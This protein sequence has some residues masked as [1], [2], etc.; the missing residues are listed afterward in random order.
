MD[1]D[2]FLEGWGRVQ[3]DPTGYWYFVPSDLPPSV[4][5]SWDL[6]SRLSE[7]DR[8]LAELGGLAR[9]LPNPHLLINPFLRREA[10][11]SSRIE[12]TQA[13]LSDLFFF[14][15]AETAQVSAPDVREVL[16]YVRAVEH[17]LTRLATLPVC[18]RLIREL[19]AKLMEGVRGEFY[20]PGEFRT[21]QNWI[22][23]PGCTLTDAAFV[24]PRVAEMQES[25]AALERYLHSPSAFP[26][27]VRQALIHYQFEAI[28]PFLDGNGR[29]GRL[30]IPVLL[31]HENILPAPLLYVSA[32]F[33]E[34]RDEYYRRLLGVSQNGEWSAWID[35]FLRGVSEQSQDAVWRTGGL[36]GLWQEYRQRVA[37][38]RPSATVLRLVD[39][40]FESPVV[41]VS[42]AA[43]RL[44]VTHR[45]ATVNINKLID[46]DILRKLPGRRRNR[47]FAATEV[48]EIA[49]RRRQA[50]DNTNSL[51]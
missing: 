51:S 18:L 33:E 6:A 26:P 4:S 41:T 5:P 28:H 30:L 36:L 17:G 35:F 46:A 21:S 13:S 24:P 27:L 50:Q 39:I 16:N 20:T 47:L 45:T 2:R 15:A 8:S 34:N 44:R 40:L 22:G 32:F 43:H 19:H 29:V 9:N 49:E 38:N 3:K 12:G 25:L 1:S 23:P 31:C 10:V 7:A 37:S 42:R 48:M 14:E 11:L